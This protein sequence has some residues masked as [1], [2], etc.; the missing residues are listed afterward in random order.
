MFLCLT[1]PAGFVDDFVVECAYIGCTFSVSSQVLPPADNHLFCCRAFYFVM[2]KRF[3]DVGQ[4]VNY[5][6]GAQLYAP[7]R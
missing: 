1:V 6:V 4:N 7:R 2:A 3:W 5:V